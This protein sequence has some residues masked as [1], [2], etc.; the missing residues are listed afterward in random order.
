M[1]KAP[2]GIRPLFLLVG[3]ETEREVLVGK[4][5]GRRLADETKPRLKP[6]R[7]ALTEAGAPDMRVYGHLTSAASSGSD[8]P[9]CRKP[10]AR[11]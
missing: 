6:I 10:W 11:A 1:S 9:S 2:L 4:P 3:L 8:T 7:H 5:A